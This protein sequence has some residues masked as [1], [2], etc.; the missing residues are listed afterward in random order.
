MVI[1]SENAL[2]IFL[3]KKGTQKE[4]KTRTTLYNQQ[5]KDD[6]EEENNQPK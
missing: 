6:K 5:G 2:S 1:F 3:T 4:A